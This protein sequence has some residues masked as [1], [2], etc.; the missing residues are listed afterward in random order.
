MERIL[1]TGATG[2]VGSCLA[3]RL[4]SIGHEVHILTRESSNKWRIHDIAADLKDHHVDLRD[5][6]R[7]ENVIS[8]IRPTVV[9]HLATYGGYSFQKETASIIESNLYG[10][11]NL[12]TACEKVGFDYFVNTGSSSEY[13]IKNSP[14]REDDLAEPLGDY[15]VSKLA[16]TL[17]CRSKAIQDNLPIITLR[18]FSPYGPWDDPRRLIPYVISSFLRNESPKLSTPNS[19]RDYI[20]IDDVIDFYVRAAKNLPSGNVYNVGSGNQY[21]IGEVVNDIQKDFKGNIGPVWGSV[22]AQR[23]EPKTWRADMSKTLQAVNWEPKVSIS[24]GLRLTTEWMRDHLKYY[25]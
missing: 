2:F 1:V 9:Y 4:V 10:T 5:I 8:N 18:L 16:A 3:R 23:A 7:L 13:G 14:M 20:Y 25:R 24:D 22:N 15:G 6:D 17:Y 11:V 21:T 12:L 19:V